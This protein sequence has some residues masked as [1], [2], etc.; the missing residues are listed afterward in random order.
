MQVHL[1]VRIYTT[2]YENLC[3]VLSDVCLT[4]IKLRDLNEAE[5]VYKFKRTNL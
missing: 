4:D 1:Y 5:N 2:P 3:K